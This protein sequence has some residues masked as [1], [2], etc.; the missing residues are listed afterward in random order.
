[1]HTTEW[2]VVSGTVIIITADI[3][4]ALR[5]KYWARTA[6]IAALSASKD[7]D[8]AYNC[9][10]DAEEA[11]NVTVA[12][13]EKILGTAE[14]LMI[15]EG[16]SKSKEDDEVEIDEEYSTPTGQKIDPIDLTVG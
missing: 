11:M 5:C 13:A 6:Q 15:V 2:F 7:L 16:V 8:E 1:M 10:D 3:I 9:A 12:L 14:T 4:A